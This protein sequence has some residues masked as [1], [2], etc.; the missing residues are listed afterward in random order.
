LEK[1]EKEHY[2]KIAAL[3]ENIIIVDSVL[4]VPLNVKPVVLQVLFV[5]L[6]KIL[7]NLEMVLQGI[8]TIMN[9]S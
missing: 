4:T 5:L 1:S 9:A 8:F 7:L 6:A 2:V 3:L